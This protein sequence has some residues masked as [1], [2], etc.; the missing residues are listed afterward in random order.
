MNKCIVFVKRKPQTFL[1]RFFSMLSTAKTCS[2]AAGSSI[3]SARCNTSQCA[4]DNMSALLA[5]VSRALPLR[6]VFR[7]SSEIQFQL[8]NELYNVLHA[9]SHERDV[10]AGGAV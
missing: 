3:F 6:M 10:T 7:F 2:P 1:M 5:Q 9:N 8:S 4:R